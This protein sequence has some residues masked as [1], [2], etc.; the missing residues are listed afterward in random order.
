MAAPARS[1]A[2]RLARMGA[3]D[4]V[5][6]RRHGRAA[7]GSSREFVRAASAADSMPDSGMP[8]SRSERRRLQPTREIV[9]AARGVGRAER[10]GDDPHR[11][12]RGRRVIGQRHGAAPPCGSR[13]GAGRTCRPACGRA[14]GA[15]PCRRRR[16]RCRRARRHR[17][18]PSGP[19]DRAGRSTMLGRARARARM[20]SA[21]ISETIGLRS[22]A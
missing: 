14:C 18:R 20:P 5:A 11:L 19:R 16:G 10:L 15:A 22:W 12:G 1:G 8:R 13:H 9:E 4:E 7:A 2:R 21:A 6:Q 17:A 3:R